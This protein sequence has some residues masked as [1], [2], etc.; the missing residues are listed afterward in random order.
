MKEQIKSASTNLM[1]SMLGSLLYEFVGKTLAV[2][3]G[4]TA[5]FGALPATLAVLGGFLGL[6]GL[7]LWKD[8]KDDEQ[9]MGII[10]TLLDNDRTFDECLKELDL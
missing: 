5:A 4:T 10:D 3:A 7:K 1:S 9:R 8:A 6:E 2:G